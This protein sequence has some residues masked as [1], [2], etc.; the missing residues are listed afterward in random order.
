VLSKAVVTQ[1]A[2]LSAIGHAGAARQ[3]FAECFLVR[4][5]QFLQAEL[6]GNN[7]VNNRVA[8]AD[9]ITFSVTN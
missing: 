8:Y 2:I 4:S 5:G 3:L 7:Y 6:I 1:L 9:K